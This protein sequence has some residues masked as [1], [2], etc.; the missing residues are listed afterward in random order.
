M[1]KGFFIKKIKREV[2]EL[3][4]IQ[5]IVGTKKPSYPFLDPTINNSITSL[6]DLLVCLENKNPYY[7]SFNKKF[8]DY[9]QTAMHRAFFSDLHIGVEGSLKELIDNQGFK[10][11]VSKHE[12]AKSIVKKIEEKLKDTTPIP[13]ELNKIL[14]LGSKFATFNDYLN[15]VLDNIES[16]DRK[17]KSESRAYFDAL[18]I[19]RNKISH[20]DMTLSETEKEKLKKAKFSKAI[21]PNGFL[22]MTFEGYKSLLMDIVRFFDRLYSNL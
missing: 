6:V 15:T 5:K 10:V 8:F 7:K 16:L 3:K 4:N 19:I 14:K 17:Y 9:K 21:L 20:S 12:L 11:F 2:R 13:K 18:N 1:N 22:Q